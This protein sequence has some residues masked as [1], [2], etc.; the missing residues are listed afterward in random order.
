MIFDFS[1]DYNLKQV[2]PEWLM[3]VSKVTIQNNLANMIQF[4]VGVKTMTSEFSGCSLL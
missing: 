3:N 2:F 4:Q 1:N